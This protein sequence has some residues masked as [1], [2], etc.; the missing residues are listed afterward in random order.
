[1]PRNL[2]A[3]PGPKMRVKFA[4]ELGDFRAQPLQLRVGILVTGQDLQVVHFLFELFQLALPRLGYFLRRLFLFFNGHALPA[5]AAA[6][7]LTRCTA[8]FSSGDAFTRCCEA[9]TATVP[10]GA[11]NSNT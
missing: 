5:T 6:S 1:M 11:S 2:R 7:L 3:L 8:S 4:P 10:S 9:T